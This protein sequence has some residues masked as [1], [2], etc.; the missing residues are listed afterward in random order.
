M[1]RERRDSLFREHQRAD[2]QAAD[3]AARNERAGFRVAEED[4]RAALQYAAR[5]L[6]EGP[7]FR[8]MLKQVKPS[9][10]ILVGE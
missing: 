2:G 1:S 8:P 5:V 10:R 3:E 6:G 4:V 9:S 7:Y